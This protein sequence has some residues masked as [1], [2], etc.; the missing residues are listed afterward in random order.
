MKYLLAVLILSLPTLA[1]AADGKKVYE[2]NCLS[3]HGAKGD[4]KGPAG[5]YM[6]P[7]ARDFTAGTSAT[8]KWVDDSVAGIT[9]ATKEGLKGTAMPAYNTLSADDLKAVVDYVVTFMPKKK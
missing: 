7:K 4:G 1:V 6:N 5:K 2:T 9:K 8:N 3:C